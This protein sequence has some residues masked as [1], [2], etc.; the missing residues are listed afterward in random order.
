[1][2][3]VGNRG[4]GGYNSEK[5]GGRQLANRS[6]YNSQMAKEPPRPFGMGNR[7]RIH[8][9]AMLGEFVGTFMFLFFAFAIA[10]IANEDPNLASNGSNP[11]QL[12]MISLGFGFS[13]ATNVFV[14]YRVSGGAFNPCVS[15]ALFLI[16][17]IS[18]VRC[19]LLCV[20]Q[21]IAGMC[22][23][24][25]VSVLTPGPVLFSNALGNGVSRSRGLFI[26]MFLTAMLVITVL[27]LAAEKHRATYMAPLGIGFSIFIGHLVGVYYTGAGINPARS[28]G[29]AIANRSFPNYHW[30]YWLGPILGTFLAVGLYKTLKYLQYE[31]ANPDQDSDGTALLYDDPN[32]PDASR[33]RGTANNEFE[34]LQENENAHAAAVASGM[35]T[36]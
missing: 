2:T 16:G 12:I 28:F 25:V 22:A 17:A 33:G 6:S 7:W 24:A 30:I 26:E 3:A 32:A 1:M 34:T 13:L 31:T 20:T 23:A 36:V 18:A 5:V 21:V 14:F 29:P 27:M 9:I 11:G 15:L 19:A 8:L 4:D 10:Q 35:N